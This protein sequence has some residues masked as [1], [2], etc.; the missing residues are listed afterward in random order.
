MKRDTV[1]KAY[2]IFYSMSSSEVDDALY[3]F[4]K[5]STTMEPEIA[6]NRLGEIVDADPKKFISM[7]GDPMFKDKVFVMKLI[8]KGFIKK[9]GTGKGD[10]MPLYYEDILLGNGLE[11][12]VVFLK[13]TENQQ[14]TIALKKLLTKK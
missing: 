4:G 3:I 12:T 8:R 2:S 9:H 5:D 7:I 11:Q 10:D 1:A 6:K 14:I 13:A